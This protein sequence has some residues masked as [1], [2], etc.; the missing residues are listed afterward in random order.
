[1]SSSTPKLAQLLAT[2][3]TR[4]GG[5]MAVAGAGSSTEST[6]L[7]ALALGDARAREWLL[8]RQRPDGAWPLGDAVPEPSW[9]SSWALIALAHAGAGS[10][11]LARGAAWLTAR[12]GWRPGLVARTLGA[13]TGQRKRIEH[14]LALRGWPWH[15]AAASWCE[16]TA[17]AL[18]ALRQLSARVV[19][20][21]AS[22]RMADGERLLW[23]RMC[24]DGGWNYGNRRVLGETIPPYPDTTALVLIALQGSAHHEDIARSFTALELLLAEH[25][26]SLAL[27]LGALAHE[28]HGRD[29]QPL[30]SALH[31]RIERRGPPLETRA[32]AFAL[33]ALDGGASRLAVSA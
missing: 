29:P 25:A 15:A 18:L 14:D 1:M 4:E 6:A 24:V 10:E 12:E 28:L 7:A 22:E 2:R 20:P 17:S 11:P 3:R 9:A 27:A 31:E 26:S 32:L 13:L 19:T 5:Y 30:R 21:G 33:L 16:P 8:S 23:N